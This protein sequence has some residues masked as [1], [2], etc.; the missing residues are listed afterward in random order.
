MQL[1]KQ[2]LISMMTVCV[3]VRTYALNACVKSMFVNRE[4]LIKEGK[5]Q[6]SEAL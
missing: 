3:C 4:R 6:L 1:C 2:S 5:W